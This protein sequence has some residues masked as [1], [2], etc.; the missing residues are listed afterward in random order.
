VKAKFNSAEFQQTPPKRK[1]PGSWGKHVTGPQKTKSHQPTRSRIKGSRGK[2]GKKPLERAH[3]N[4]GARESI[5]LRVSKWKKKNLKVDKPLGR[6]AATSQ[7]SIGEE[8]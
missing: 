7:K 2:K 5:K 3:T 1:S 4:Q 6:R 8:N